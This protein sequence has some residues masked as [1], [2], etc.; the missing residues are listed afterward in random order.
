MLGMWRVGQRQQAASD[1]TRTKIVALF[2]NMD[3]VSFSAL[4]QT[5]TGQTRQSTGG[6]LGIPHEWPS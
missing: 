2:L 1:P 5:N 6:S 4:D 3:C